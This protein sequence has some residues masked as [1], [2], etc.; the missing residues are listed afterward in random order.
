MT[1][2]LRTEKLGL[3][4]EPPLMKQFRVLV[5]GML[6][7]LD[8]PELLLEVFGCQERW[9]RQGHLRRGPPG[10]RPG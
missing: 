5:D 6:P 4:A 7:R 9:V 10:L 1:P 2:E 3:V 8:F